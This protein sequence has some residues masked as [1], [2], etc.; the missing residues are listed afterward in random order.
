MDAVNITKILDF[1]TVTTVT[2]NPLILGILIGIWFFILVLYLI[3]AS[4]IRAR[5]SSGTKL[6]GSLLSKPTGWIPVFFWIL[7]LGLYFIF[8][9][10]PVWLGK[11]IN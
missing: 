8:L 1:Q 4:C 3:T 6:K 2:Q 10:F 9:I 7:Q 5:T 11:S